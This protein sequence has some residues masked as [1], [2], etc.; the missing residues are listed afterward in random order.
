RQLTFHCGTVHEVVQ[1]SLAL[2]SRTNQADVLPHCEG[3]ST[4][5]NGS[6]A[7][8]DVAAVDQIAEMRLPAAFDQQLV[9]LR[10]CSLCLRQGQFESLDLTNAGKR[11]PFLDERHGE[12]LAIGHRPTAP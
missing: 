4:G 8:T 9:P 2:V 7:D 11:D 12:M 1:V 3:L 5:D 10:R 6:C